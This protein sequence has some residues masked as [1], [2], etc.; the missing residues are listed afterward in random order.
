ML[1]FSTPPAPDTMPSRSPAAEV[2]HLS[3]RSALWVSLRCSGLYLA[4]CVT[5]GRGPN[6]DTSF[7][8]GRGHGFRFRV[9]V[10]LLSVPLRQSTMV[11]DPCLSGRVLRFFLGLPASV[12]VVDSLPWSPVASLASPIFVILKWIYWGKAVVPMAGCVGRCSR[13]DQIA[14]AGEVR[15][16]FRHDFC[17]Q[18]IALLRTAYLV[19]HL[20][21]FAFIIPIAALCVNGFLCI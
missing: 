6:P 18:Q 8:L 15:N 5:L 11:L 3:F 16:G 1:G 17:I 4:W 2:Y 12:P 20:L 9:S 21:W 10:I 7:A 13:L 14:D 19:F